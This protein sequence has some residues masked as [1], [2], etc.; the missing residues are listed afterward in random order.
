[1]EYSYCGEEDS[2]DHVAFECRR[3]AS[4]RN[5]QVREVGS[6]LHVDNVVGLML[7]SSRKWEQIS[8]FL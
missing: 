6:P 3:W 2:P 8:G 1:M 5:S 4:D 7:E